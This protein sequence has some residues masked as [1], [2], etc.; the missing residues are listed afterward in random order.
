MS[1][2]MIKAVAII[3]MIIDHIGI[4]FFPQIVVFRIIGRIALPLFAWQLSISVDKTHDMKKLLNRIFLFSMISQVPYFILFG[5]GLNI[6]FSFTLSIITL[7]FY[8]KE[9]LAGYFALVASIIISQATNLEYGWYAIMM[10]FLFYCF[11]NDI[12][13]SV[14]AQVVLNIVYFLIFPS[15]QPYALLSFLIIGLY[16]NEKGKLYNCRLA[17]YSIYPLHMILLIFL[18]GGLSWTSL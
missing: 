5:N 18:K 7:I 17:M 6:F 2:S 8:K 14:L 16:N 9:K 4:V 12:R 15:I 1:S 13:K 10:V 11:K 3:T